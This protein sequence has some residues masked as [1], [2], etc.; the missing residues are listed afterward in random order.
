[1]YHSGVDAKPI[2]R[3]GDLPWWL[4]APLLL[5]SGLALGGAYWDDAWHTE[6]GRDA[7]FIAPH[8]AIYGGVSLAG[9]ALSLWALLVVRRG[10][11]RAIASRAPLQLALLSVAVTLASAPLDNAW[12]A[13]FAR[14]A[15]IWSPPHVLGILGTAGLALA[16]LVQLSAQP[17]PWARLLS[18]A[19]G[20][21][22][23]S[24]LAFLV[25]EYES[26]V[27]QFSAVWY[28]PVLAVVSSLA[29]ALVRLV[30][31]R[32]AAATGA[33]AAHLL[34]LLGVSV[35]LSVSGFATPRLPLLVLPAAAVDWA[36]SR[37]LPLLG[38]AVLF[39][40]VLFAAYLPAVSISGPAVPVS[41]SQALG[42]FPL[43]LLGVVVVFALVEGKLRVP[44][45]RK[46]AAS[47]A[48]LTACLVFAASA[49]A[50]DPGQGPAAGRM[51]LVASLR[52][53]RASVVAEA[54]GV[55]CAGGQPLG[56]VGRRGGTVRRGTLRGNDCRY[57]GVITLPEHGR[58]FVYADLRSGRGTI[59][60]WLP[61]KV[62]A[63]R[64]FVARSRFAYFSDRKPGNAGKV[65]AGGAMYLAVLAFLVVVIRVARRAAG[66]TRAE[67]SRRLPRPVG[68]G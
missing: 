66:A 55:A 48:M 31:P 47:F 44:R 51:N 21:L 1:M 39:V 46:A 60:S 57:T 2:E 53:D 54:S 59:E 22:V 24:A 67:S 30:V 38:R 9:G 5:G 52:G 43:A 8:L 68:S 7:F 36:S 65:A 58:W 56:L 64:R 6:R 23:L 33:A 26:D 37:R 16:L 17:S 3:G 40:G 50:H 35:F 20:G 42:G 28:L 14:D 18:P 12:H 45:R 13:A 49:A 41:I 63:D 32:G 25:V 34:F 29:F 4:V 27:P 19:A 62:G 15:V 11:W 10:G 61:I